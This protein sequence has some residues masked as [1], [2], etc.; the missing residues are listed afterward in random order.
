MMKFMGK[1]SEKLFSADTLLKDK[2]PLPSSILEK[3]AKLKLALEECKCTKASADVSSGLTVQ[4]FVQKNNSTTR[5]TPYALWIP[6]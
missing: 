3:I 4:Y 5:H 6:M 2:L 1:K